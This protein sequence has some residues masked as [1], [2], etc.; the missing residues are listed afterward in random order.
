[1]LPPQ[2]DLSGEGGLPL[3]LSPQRSAFHPYFTVDLPVYVL[4]VWMPIVLALLS[5]TLPRFPMSGGYGM[6][7]SC[8][9][10]AQEAHWVDGHTSHF[11]IL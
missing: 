1:M 7:S 4:Q 10:P 3:A 11:T 9:R 8:H 2:D 6:V 5:R